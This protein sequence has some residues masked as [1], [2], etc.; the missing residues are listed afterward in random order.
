[1]PKVCRTYLGGR[2]IIAAAMLVIGAASPNTNAKTSGDMVSPDFTRSVSNNSE[3]AAPDLSVYDAQ[4]LREIAQQ[5]YRVIAHLNHELSQTDQL[6]TDLS[7][8]K[9]ESAHLRKECQNLRAQITPQP[10]ESVKRSRVS[11]LPNRVL[12][13]RIQN[14]SDASEFRTKPGPS[15]A[16]VATHDW[17]HAPWKYSYR[18]GLIDRN[19]QIV[20]MDQE[21]GH[22]WMGPTDGKGVDP[23][24]VVFLGEF[25]NLSEFAYRYWIVIKVFRY[26]RSDDDNTIVERE[27]GSWPY[28]TSVLGPNQTH[29]FEVKVPITEPVVANLRNRVEIEVIPVLP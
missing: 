8:L 3:M 27:I 2:A 12:P 1:M 11:I 23:D 9:A 28:R 4:A 22:I 13:Q 10:H 29:R 7:S 21:K 24:Q 17:D 26:S 16:S 25:T 15:S 6:R 20:A 14:Q 5:L 19:G 18:P